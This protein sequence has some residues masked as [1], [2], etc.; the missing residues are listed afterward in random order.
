MNE[1]YHCDN[2]FSDVHM[3]FEPEPTFTMA[4]WHWRDKISRTLPNYTS[5]S[6]RLPDDTSKFEFKAARAERFTGAYALFSYY[7]IC[8]GNIGG[9]YIQE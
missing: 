7:R 6:T 1:A 4:E 5:T 9:V 3:V 2:T 8:F